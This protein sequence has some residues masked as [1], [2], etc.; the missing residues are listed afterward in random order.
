MYPCKK[1]YNYLST[2]RLP[3]PQRILCKGN[4]VLFAINVSLPLLRLISVTVFKFTL[5]PVLSA[6]L[7][8]LSLSLRIPHNRLSTVDSQS[9][10][11]FGPSTWNDLPFL[12]DRTPVWTPSNQTSRHVFFQNN[13]LA[14]FSSHWCYLFPPQVPVYNNNNNNMSS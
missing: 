1:E 14:S 9:F 7:L 5:P 10:S 12:S 6:L 4:T 13:T 8:I 3:I 11:V 2:C